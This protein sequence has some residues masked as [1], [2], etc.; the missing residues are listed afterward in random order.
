MQKLKKANPRILSF[1]LGHR[2][3]MS[4]RVLFDIAKNGWLEKSHSHKRIS[5][6]WREQS[7][8]Q[9]QR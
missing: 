8:V 6:L 1:I 7:T 2:G 9:Q 5:R 4:P 3:G